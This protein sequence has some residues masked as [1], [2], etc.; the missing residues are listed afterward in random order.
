MPI[1]K[2]KDG[3]YVNVLDTD[4]D[5]F[6]KAHP[7]A[8]TQEEYAGK[9]YRV[10]ATDYSEFRKAKDEY[11][12]RMA[13]H[14]REE[15]RMK[16]D[17][18]YLPGL[19]WEHPVSEV[20]FETPKEEK[21]GSDG[22]A[23][24]GTPA[25]TAMGANVKETPAKALMNDSEGVAMPKVDIPKVQAPIK[26]DTVVKSP[27][28]TEEQEE[29]EQGALEAEKT[30][31]PKEI[32]ELEEKLS[33]G[34]LAAQARLS[35]QSQLDKKKARFEEIYAE[36]FDANRKAVREQTKHLREVVD[37]H[38]S[39]AHQQQGTWTTFP[40]TAGAFSVYTPTKKSVVAEQAQ[41]N[42]DRVEEL[43]ANADRVAKGQTWVG[44]VGHGLADRATDL[45][46][47]QDLLN[48]TMSVEQEKVVT[49]AMKKADRGEKLTDAE[50]ALLDSEALRIAAQEYFK[51]TW[52]DGYKIGE[53]TGE[54]LPFMVEMALN[55]VSKA[56][57]A[58]KGLSLAVLKRYAKRYGTKEAVK[59]LTKRGGKRLAADIAGATAMSATTGAGGVMADAERRGRGQAQFD[60][61]MR[62]I[63]H[64]EGD[65]HA[66][67]NAFVARSIDNVTEMMPLFRGVTRTTQKVFKKVAPKPLREAIEGI[68]GSEWA[69]HVDDFAQRTQWHGPIEE[70][71]EEV[72]A[73]ILNAAL[74]GD[75]SLDEFFTVENQLET[76]LG[77]ALMG[78]TMSTVKTLGYESAKTR[79]RKSAE[80]LDSDMRNAMGASWDALEIDLRNPETAA[81]VLADMRM[82]G[83]GYSQREID[84]ATRYAQLRAK[85]MGAEIGEAKLAETN[86][87][88]VAAHY[89]Y[90]SGNAAV[91][92]EQKADVEESFERA[93]AAMR[94]V[95]GEN[96]MAL[97]EGDNFIEVA[98]QF[99]EHGADSELITNYINAR[100]AREGMMDRLT[101]E[102][103]AATANVDA[104][105]DQVTNRETGNVQ[106]VRMKD[107]SVAHVVS[108]EVV[109][110]EDGSVDNDNSSKNL[111]IFRDGKLEFT[112]PHMVEEASAPVNAESHKQER[113]SE[114][115]TAHLEATEAGIE[116]VRRA[117]AATEAVETNGRVM[118]RGNQEGE[119]VEA[120]VLP[121]DEPG[122]VY[123]R[124]AKSV[125]GANVVEIPMAEYTARYAGRVR[126]ERSAEDAQGGVVA[127]DVSEGSDSVASDGTEGGASDVTEGGALDVSEGS[128]GVEVGSGDVQGEGEAVSDATA[129]EGVSVGASA[130]ALSRMPKTEQGEVDYA[131]AEPS[132][133]AQAFLEEVEGDTE[134]AINLARETAEEKRKEATTLAETAPQTAGLSPSEKAKAVREHK[135]QVAQAEAEATQW[136]NI[137][138]VLQQ[139]QQV[140]EEAP[141]QAKPSVQSD[142]VGDQVGDQVEV[143]P[144][145]QNEVENVTSQDENTTENVGDS[146]TQELTEEEKAKRREEFQQ[147]V[148]SVTEVASRMAERWGRLLNVNVR[149]HTDVST[150][151]NKEAVERINRGDVVDGWY[152]PKTGEV[153]VYVPGV[154]TRALMDG[155][156]PT[157]RL[158]MT[159]RHE[160]VA[161]KG[162]REILGL[163]EYNAVMRSVWEGMNEAERKTW[164]AYVNG[165]ANNVSDQIAAADEMCAYISE[166][167]EPSTREMTL[168]ERLV[169]AIKD[170]FK[171]GEMTVLES[172]IRDLLKANY[173]YMREANEANK[174]AV[175][176]QAERVK[177]EA[178]KSTNVEESSGEPLSGAFGTIYTQFKGKAKEAIAFLLD[179]KEGEAVAALHHPEIGDIDLVWGKEGTGKSDGFGL[180]KLA[181][182]HPEVLD[183]LQEILNDMRVTA[184]SANRVQLES[185]TH[186]AAVRLTWDNENKNW[187]LTAF[188]KKNSV[189]D[190]TTDT[191]ETSNGGKRNDTATPQNTVSDSKVTDNSSAEQKNAGENVVAPVNITEAANQDTEAIKFSVATEDA[192]GERIRDYAKSSQGKKAGWTPEKVEGIIE[193]TR[194]LI[195]AIDATMRGNE[196]YDAFADREP[197]IRTDWRD[198]ELKPIVTWTRANIEYK[199]D[200]SADLLCVN[201]DGI[202]SV[203]SH[204]RMVDIMGRITKVREK[205]ASGKTYD[206]SFAAD[207]YTMLYDILKDMGFVVPCKGCFDAAGRFKM[208]PSVAQKFA[209]DVNDVI[210]ERNK[211]PK[212]FDKAVKA[213]AKGEASAE[214]FPVKYGDKM[215]AIRAGVAGDNATEHIQWTDLMSAEGQTKL[216]ATHGGIFRAWQR[217]G[218]GRP[219]DKLL[220]EPYY[221]DI[222]AQ[223][224]TIIGAYGEKTPSFRD[225]SVNTGTGLRRN[226]HSELRPTLFVDEIQFMR[227][228]FLKGLTVFKYTKDLDDV[229]MFG[230]M[231]T[232][233]NM[234]FFP[235]HVKGTKASGL[236]AEGNYIAAEESVGAREFAYTGEDGKRHY[237]GMK[238][239]EE[240]KRLVNKDVSLSSV[241]FSIPHLIKALTDVPTVSDKSGIW[242]SLIPFHSSGATT[243]GL[244]A[245]GLGM[246][247][248][249]GV[250]HGFEEAMTDYGKGVTNFEAVQNDRFGEGWVI[251]QG[252][253]E[254]TAVEPG[255]KLEFVN[256]TH[257]YNEALGVHLFAS[258]YALDSEVP[259]DQ[260]HLLND[261]KTRKQFMHPLSIDYNERVRKINTPTAYQDAA[262][263]YLDILPK[264]GL[265]PRFQFNVAE[266]V[267]L[268][269]CKDANV[270]P[271]HPKLGWKGEGHAWSPTDAESYYSLFCDYGMTDP[272]TGE[273]APHKPIGKVNKNGE[274]V[275][276]L[277]KDAVEI[278]K[279]ALDRYTEVRQSEDPKVDEAIN[280]FE[281]KLKEQGR[282]MFS[283]KERANMS[284]AE[285]LERMS[286]GQGDDIRFSFI[287]E[288]GAEALDKAEEATTRL[289]NLNI[290]REMESAGKDARTIKIAT[291]WERGAD[292]KWRYETEDVK[293]KKDF[294]K[295]KDVT[296]GD[297][298]DLGELGKAYPDLKDI[299]VVLDTNESE[300]RGT[301][302][303]KNNTITLYIMDANNTRK[304]AGAISRNIPFT[305]FIAEYMTSSAKEAVDKTLV[306]EIQHAIQSREGFAKGGNKRMRIGESEERLGY[307]G[308]RK[309]AGEVEARNV[310]E[311]MGKTMDER[312]ASLRT[313]TQDVAD[314]DQ[315]FI[316]DALE[317][318]SSE[319]NIDAVNARFNAELDGYINGRSKANM[320]FHVGNPMGVMQIFL[321]NL[322]IVMRPRVI[323]KATNTKHDV[324]V[325]ALHDLPKRISAPIFVFQRDDNALGVLTEIKDNNGKNVCVA[326]ELNKIIQDGGSYLEVNDIRS[327]HGRD[328]ENL[329][330]PIIHNNTLKYVDKEKGL[331]WLSS[332]SSNYQ[333]EITKQDLVSATKVVENFENPQI[334]GQEND[335]DTLFSYKPFGGNSGYVGYSMSKRAAQAREEGRFP[336][337]D[338]KK[339][340]G[341]TEKVL[342]ALVKAGIVDNAE[343]HHTSMYGNKT[344]FYG[345][346]DDAYADV[347]AENKKAV[348]KIL[349]GKNADGT[350]FA[351][352]PTEN[353][354]TEMSA[355]IPEGWYPFLNNLDEN[356]TE[357]E[358]EAVLIERFGDAYAKLKEASENNRLY[359]EYEA[360]KGRM[361][362]EYYA[363]VG[364]KLKE[365]FEERVA[366]ASQLAGTVGDEAILEE[367]AVRFSVVTDPKEISFF[368]NSE[369]II[370]YR[371]MVMREDGSLGSPMA[372]GLRTKGKKQVKTDFVR[373]GEIEKAEENPDL[374][375]E[376]GKVD[377]VKP[378][379]KSV[380]GVDY[381]PYIH[382]RPDKVN[383]Q[384]KQAWERD[385]L[386]Y[387]E[388]E[389]AK[390]D[391]AEGYH[392]D[393]AK[394]SVGVHDWSGG[395]KLILSRYDKPVRIVPWEEVADDWMAHFGDK[396]IHFDIIPPKLLPILAERGANII[397]PH[398][399]MGKACNDAYA[400]WN[401]Q[402]GRT[403]FSSAPGSLVAMHNLTASDL[404]HVV[405]MGGIA[406]PSMA[407]VDSDISVLDNFGEITLIAPRD[408]IEKKT[409]KNAGTWAADAY[410]PR[411]PNVEYVIPYK[412]QRE[413]EQR[414]VDAGVNKYEAT[415]FVQRIEDSGKKWLIGDRTAR[416][417]FANEGREGES[418]EDYI[419]RLMN[420]VV[421]KEQIFMGY[422][423]NGRRYAKHTLANVSR[424]MKK[425][426]RAGAE[427]HFGVGSIRAQLTPIFKTIAQI[428]KNKDRIVSA[429]EWKEA[430]ESV[431]KRYYALADEI[432]YN[433]LGE[434][435]LE[436]DPK[437]Y[438]EREYDIEITNEEEAQIKQLAADLTVMPTEYFETKF[439]R[440][441]MLNEFVGAIIPENA[442]ERTRKILDD[443]GIPYKTYNQDVEGD[444]KQVVQEYTKELDKEVGGVRFSYRSTDKMTRLR[445]VLGTMGIRVNEVESENGRPYVVWSFLD[446]CLEVAKP[447]DIDEGVFFA[448]VANAIA[449]GKDIDTALGKENVDAFVDDVIADVFADFEGDADFDSALRDAGFDM[450]KAVRHYL[451]KMSV[452]SYSAGGG[453]ITYLE[454][455]L[456]EALRAKYG[457]GTF[458]GYFAFSTLHYLE[459]EGEPDSGLI[460]V[461]S[462][463]ASRWEAERERRGGEGSDSVASD[464]TEGSDGTSGDDH[465]ITRGKAK[466]VLRESREERTARVMYEEQVE[467]LGCEFHLHGVCKAIWD[468]LKSKNGERLST[469]KRNFK[470]LG[471]EWVEVAQDRTNAIRALQRAIEKAGGE[472]LSSMEDVWRTLGALSS[473][474]YAEMQDVHR[475]LVAPLIDVF[476]DI[477]KKTG[478]DNDQIE[479]YLYCKHA[480][481]RNA[482][483]GGRAYEETMKKG[484]ERVKALHPEDASSLTEREFKMRYAEELAKV[485]ERAKKLLNKDYSGVKELLFGEKKV[486]HAKVTETAEQV[487]RD[488]ERLVGTADVTQLWSSIK[489]LTDFSLKKEYDCGLI[490]KELYN[491]VRE[492]YANYVPLRGWEN[493]YAGDIFAYNKDGDV[494][495]GIQRAYKKANGR[496][497]QAK[498][499][500][501]HTIA[502]AHSAIACGNK[503]KAKQK[504]LF[505]AEN[506]PSDLLLTSD[507]WYQ[508][509]ADGKIEA[510][511]ADIHED[512]SPEEVAEEIA[513]FEARMKEAEKAGLAKRYK[514]D[515]GK[516][517]G[518][519]MKPF[520]EKQHGVRVMVN[521]REHMVWVVGNPRAAMVLNGSLNDT[522]KHGWW[523]KFYSRLMRFQNS[524]NTSWNFNFVMG[525]VQR[526]FQTA[527]NS[528]LINKGAAYAKKFTANYAKIM[529]SA[530]G[531]FIGGGVGSVVG[532]GVGTAV[533]TIV[534]GG[535]GAVINTAMGEGVLPIVGLMYRYNEG[536]LDMEEP[537]DR[538]FYEF[539][540]NGGI[541]GIT[542]MLAA[543]EAQESF[544]SE[545]DK[546]VHG[547]VVSGTKEVVGG[548][549]N[550][551]ELL[552]NAFENAT[553][554]ATFL[555]S[556]EMGSSMTEAVMDAKEHSVNFN[557]RGTGAWS[558]VG[559]MIHTISFA[560][561]AL[562]ALRLNREWFANDWKKTTG[563]FLGY[564]AMGMTNAILMSLVF[565]GDDDDDEPNEDW[566]GL[567]RF[568]RYNNFNVLAGD[569][570]VKVSIPHEFRAPFAIGNM[571][572]DV[573]NGKISQRD[574]IAEIVAMPWNYSPVAL[575]GPGTDITDLNDVAFTAVGEML[576]SV[577]V[578][579]VY[580]LWRNENYLG[581]RIHNMSDYNKDVPEFQRTTKRTRSFYVAFSRGVNE[582][583]GGA[584]NRRSPVEW[585]GNNPGVVQYLVEQRIGGGVVAWANAFGAIYDAVDDEAEVDVYDIPFVKTIWAKG[586]KDNVFQTMVWNEFEG[587]QNSYIAIDSELRR[588]AKNTELTLDYK[589]QRIAAM[590][591]NGELDNYFKFKGYNAIDEEYQR[592]IKAAQKDGDDDEVKRLREEQFDYRKHALSQMKD[593]V[594]TDTELLIRAERVRAEV[595]PF[596]KRMSELNSALNKEDAREEADEEKIA[597]LEAELKA[598]SDPEI[599]KKIGAYE[600]YLY[601]QREY[602]SELKLGNSE[603]A[604]DAR[605][606]MLDAARLME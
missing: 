84:A 221:G 494:A 503:N 606:D 386:V 123:V 474:N 539:A 311:R 307:E 161:H 462:R 452:E 353:P 584:Y 595:Q 395:G 261:A 566:Y 602:E 171:K 415:A 157:T 495:D 298:A 426:G 456:T 591:Q 346:V 181:K 338:F 413:L 253:K 13:Y 529:G 531:A 473:K 427:G 572:V 541:T 155:V 504:F 242:G 491:E 588:N 458:D 205:D 61:D 351:E 586:G 34:G 168:F 525:N 81:R 188:E 478:L 237:D 198:G 422:T 126:D 248:A 62:Y 583:L 442:S 149:V 104:E 96:D 50:D 436:R 152:E 167:T 468:A 225:M 540:M 196:F 21:K 371:N 187:L 260:R 150:I 141:T 6:V 147:W 580:D 391:L 206:L 378:D 326:I 336:K 419:D 122:M 87:Q 274:R 488:F 276:E 83:S 570:S 124:G 190:N 269:M 66:V 515:F 35:L 79:A 463:I 282:L 33:K 445:G 589:L 131:H 379:G 277:P 68:T 571:M 229:R 264:I 489:A 148:D 94:E 435:L 92:V 40:S 91:E 578:K 59:Q 259:A 24:Y 42:L 233:F 305:K 52:K 579:D 5:A 209:Q 189:S 235:E 331:D 16:N 567:S 27:V 258:G 339:E 57:S 290:A 411:Y 328:I 135:A 236:D 352:L 365:F 249:N 294:W 63:G 528:G 111:V 388:C 263:Y 393:K 434:A 565:D 414:A 341:V 7:D 509:G 376:N 550:N 330:L 207:D 74:V 482:L 560:N 464:R 15:E 403:M 9:K 109:L 49:E 302:S 334:L 561:A 501:G 116:E 444:R 240:A 576:P 513:D 247:R 88:A 438:L 381:N 10:D 418:F 211:N 234:S 303:H 593:A 384:F 119:V 217:T 38:V 283:A 407:V 460:D 268:Q 273:W 213:E 216:L 37:K 151:S 75:Q 382:N 410:S 437:G 120:E 321:P 309:L 480:L 250:G 483:M 272:A 568:N 191:G 112:N 603:A 184:R 56:G 364:E 114:I 121:S 368:E 232:K 301:Y 160:V 230:E 396:G 360:N 359:H 257:Y 454:N 367:G 162:L 106:S 89:S 443:A 404:G 11:T 185:E 218:A 486:S 590:E 2:Q 299:K 262:D 430:E 563:V 215:A 350:P 337:T 231:G 332:A 399:G 80:R 366:T 348:K 4:V 192:L 518:L 64:T 446:D 23:P 333:Q 431:N 136:E 600:D 288:K 100:S 335:G 585:A 320:M 293:L 553:R 358:R 173:A 245:Q 265:V 344:P 183:N 58:V 30:N 439:E 587:F 25:Q 159:I 105:V 471:N 499:I 280:R 163:E 490:S 201:N 156:H 551:I 322:P 319:E 362:R 581:A 325:E 255:H 472:A 86:P 406:N 243:A 417:L 222:M 32:A 345:W 377:L 532:G 477:R 224:G 197:T 519:H 323:N 208:L 577:L 516:E 497:S 342:D 457:A 99:V 286:E 433:E 93:D 291:G 605:K 500:L 604:E 383:T 429:E 405:K 154:V 450:R 394:L 275:F 575:V 569:G 508:I 510:V 420:E 479:R 317:S 373:L 467:I 69:K 179:K 440:P 129:S 537:M 316:Y 1:F 324:S 71:F 177:R 470:R 108:G 55:P 186:Q 409:G 369:K 60:E 424:I 596:I 244:A 475:R 496:K 137:A 142:Q 127:P 441:V 14:E 26:T 492:M 354:Y 252:K 287:G 12:Q 347:Y 598:I 246:A 398:K 493:D 90:D 574:A 204:P 469:L 484:Y 363:K 281:D 18:M 597:A 451:S 520:Q 145:A 599:L 3:T 166:L 505:L 506:H 22:I 169:Q 538:A 226:S 447:E 372:S 117:R 461:M 251:L 387:V 416:A 139:S 29:N 318:A 546:K 601:Y 313:E 524:S 312:R 449:L 308:Y 401:E 278:A 536:K 558:D 542:S 340:Y 72:E 202:E 465:K 498:D 195:G 402:N 555:T 548:L 44:G 390:D 28:F 512:M 554:F 134:T 256:G 502:M 103:E 43:I 573:Y 357:A 271:N 295:K 481:E 544:E 82:E 545:V 107:G 526:D 228:A 455:R 292:N 582:L 535:A 432:G 556:R 425:E 97:L 36:E 370:G 203:L 128:A 521:G 113:K 380:G 214:G 421:Q 310:S 476:A 210:D 227:D 385:N 356:L 300:R 408:L 296:L 76:F 65:E 297:V 507:M 549:F 239:F 355:P 552:N 392:A 594:S 199:Y 349:E 8:W 98:N 304:V 115:E 533:G 592:R 143:A 31:L 329:I 423:D 522:L 48:P 39:D 193:E 564:V 327:I 485:E 133:A 343:W 54:S 514:N 212:K 180:A 389:I 448:G 547:G 47:W 267:F 46:T 511:T 279:T 200:M 314:K 45:R 85:Q 238:G 220:A 487:V 194:A 178:K 182:Y 397:A 110:R 170:F 175:L 453:F 523:R 144:Q 67:R 20:K 254:G 527:L 466:R 17:P 284:P 19:D 223:T 306:H 285:M 270:D 41:Y 102:I 51:S 138:E 146:K 165:D 130:S 557:M 132:L 118:L 534:G 164:L 101:E 158:E 241:I 459:R 77:V 375:D 374:A 315:I 400:E 140:A 174:Q 428:Q 412:K 78:A 289:D 176:E 530:A 266:D 153:H 53:I 125:F 517:L 219:K 172:E 543:E 70:Y 562:Q 361:E 73:G 95:F 559:W